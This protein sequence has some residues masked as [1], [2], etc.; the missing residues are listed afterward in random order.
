MALGMSLVGGFLAFA[1]LVAEVKVVALT[2][3]L[4]LSIAGI[5]KEV[6]TVV[7]ATI[8]LGEHLTECIGDRR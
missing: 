5:F 2:S 3:G 7:G 4:S 6:L 8:V 1:L